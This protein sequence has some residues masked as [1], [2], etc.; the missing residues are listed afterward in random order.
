MD[1]TGSNRSSRAGLPEEMRPGLRVCRDTTEVART[2]CRLF[3]EWAWQFIAREGAFC[4]AL[5]GGE[6]PRE[7]YRLLASDEFR[8]QVDWGKVHLFWSDERAVPPDHLESN[9]GMARRE[10]LI[11]I[12]I[13]FA[14]VHRME[15]HGPNLGRAA[16]DY[17]EVLRLNLRRD[18]R[19][20]PRFHV[21]LLDLGADGHTASLFATA[22]KSRETLRWVSTPIVPKLGSRRM[23]LTLPVL[24][25]AHQVLF[26]VTGDEKAE[27]LRAVL[28][29]N[30]DP[31]L[32]AQ[33]VTVPNG[34]R[35]ILADEAAARLA[36]GE[37]LSR[38]SPIAPRRVKP[39]ESGQGKS[40]GSG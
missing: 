38:A 27:A 6:T 7:M 39:G 10:L 32:P 20:L 14:H 40:R 5:A 11:R 35:V 1:D 25:A 31:P 36:V 19:G 23:T 26:L 12:A 22:R 33:L 30:H 28:E 16:Q 34:R 9:Y 2:A 29:A 15:A 4:V 37:P 21:I 13:P 8:P 24:N 3:V 17:E 18:A